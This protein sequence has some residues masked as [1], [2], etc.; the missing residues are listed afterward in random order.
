MTAANVTFLPT[1][2]N[3]LRIERIRTEINAALARLSSG[4]RTDWTEA[5]LQIAT[6]LLEAKSMVP[7][8][9]AANDWFKANLNYFPSN[10]RIA[11]CG[12]ATNID[13][14]REL[15]NRVERK[16]YQNI[17]NANRHLFMDVPKKPEPERDHK[18]RVYAP[19]NRSMIHY[20]LKLGE[21]TMAKIRGTS[22]DSA[23]EMEE[24]LML[25]RGAEEGELQPIVRQLVEDAAAGKPVSAL[26][27]SARQFGALPKR[28]VKH[29]QQAWIKRMTHP[30]ELASLQEKTELLVYLLRAMPKTE[31]GEIIEH[32]IDHVN[33]KEDGP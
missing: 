8:G 30:W 16:S 11:L 26:A 17:W 28:V 4:N 3:N 22:L 12:L 6:A 19:R 13:V 5:S 31:A 25:N 15:L 21:L 33:L 10:E 2:G 24:L 32:L 7:T 27:T 1:A 9:V 23:K 14:A 29:L 18:R 20:T